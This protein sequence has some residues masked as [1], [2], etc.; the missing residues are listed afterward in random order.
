MRQFNG[1]KN[2]LIFDAPVGLAT[3]ARAARRYEVCR[4]GFTAVLAGNDVI[5][6]DCPRVE[7]FF[8]IRALMAIAQDYRATKHN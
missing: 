4:Y 1:T 2:A 7:L 8:A 5:H 6:L 3:I